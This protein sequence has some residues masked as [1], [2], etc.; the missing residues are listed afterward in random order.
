MRFQYDSGQRRSRLDRL[1]GIL[2]EVPTE[3]RIHFEMASFTEGACLKDIID[4]VVRY[5]D[6]LGMNEQVCDI[7]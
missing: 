6:S 1:S 7:V 4:T 5:S 3:T 2:S